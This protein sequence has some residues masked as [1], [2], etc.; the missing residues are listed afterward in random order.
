MMR[1]TDT[2]LKIAEL[3]YSYRNSKPGK[4]CIVKSFYALIETHIKKTTIN[5]ESYN[6]RD[7]GPAR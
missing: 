5:V 6:D 2:V 7:T 1:R 4:S 3:D